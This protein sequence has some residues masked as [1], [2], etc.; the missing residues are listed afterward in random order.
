M[1]DCSRLGRADLKRLILALICAWAMGLPALAQT[2]DARITTSLEAQGYRI[3]TLYYTWL[4]RIYV[5]A[6]SDTVRREMVFNPATGEVLRDY[7]VQL[8]GSQTAETRES[9]DRGNAGGTNS[10]DPTA[11]GISTR[12]DDGASDENDPDAG[13]D[14]DVPDVVPVDPVIIPPAE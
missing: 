13:P 14:N 3:V 2:M 1:L 6:E 11:M 7:A 5:I 12:G 8:G 4:G 9:S 10:G